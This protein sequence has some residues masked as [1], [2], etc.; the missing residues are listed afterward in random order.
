MIGP[1]T[2]LNFQTLVKSSQPSHLYLCYISIT[3]WIISTTSN[4]FKN[5][6]TYPVIHINGWE[7][8]LGPAAHVRVRV[9]ARACVCIRVYISS[10]KSFT[11][12]TNLQLL[13]PASDAILSCSNPSSRPTLWAYC[14]S[15][16]QSSTTRPPPPL[17]ILPSDLL[18]GVKFSPQGV[19]PVSTPQPYG[20]ICIQAASWLGAGPGCGLHPEV[21]ERWREREGAQGSGGQF[22]WFRKMGFL[23]TRSKMADPFIH[24]PWNANWFWK[25]TWWRKQL[26]CFHVSSVNMYWS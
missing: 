6:F 22:G 12:K 9:H 13:F 8:A 3:Y 19:C 23:Q 1:V 10:I 18:L 16:G 14:W 15:G 24:V 20:C 11:N 17:F 25:P 7:V 4:G 21:R 26:N 5:H 2:T